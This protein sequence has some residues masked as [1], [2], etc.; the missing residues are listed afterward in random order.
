MFLSFVLYFILILLPLLP[1][2]TSQIQVIFEVYRRPIQ[3]IISDMDIFEAN[4]LP[5]HPLVNTNSTTFVD[6]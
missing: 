2:R 6:T 1:L 3:T 4:Y 5:Y